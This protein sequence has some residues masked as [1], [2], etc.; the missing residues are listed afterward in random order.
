MQKFDE[1]ELCRNN[2]DNPALKD[3]LTAIASESIDSY[4]AIIA[5]MCSNAGCQTD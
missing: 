4:P 2:I 3:L 5:R 1:C